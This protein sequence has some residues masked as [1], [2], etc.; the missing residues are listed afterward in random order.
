MGAEMSKFQELYES[1]MP[2]EK[3]NFHLKG[4]EQTHAL[5]YGFYGRE[6]GVPL[7]RKVGD[8]FEKISAPEKDQRLLFKSYDKPGDEEDLLAKM[9]AQKAGALPVG[10]GHERIASVG[11]QEVHVGS[12]IANPEMKIAMDHFF[13]GIAGLDLPQD[14]VKAAIEAIVDKYKKKD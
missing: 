1:N 9:A 10:P 5:G 4:P 8:K 3:E 2:W 12:D 11:G 6:K 14:I 7:F 13:K